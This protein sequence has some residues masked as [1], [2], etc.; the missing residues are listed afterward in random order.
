LISMRVPSGTGALSSLYWEK[1]GGRRKGGGKGKLRSLFL[2]G[3]I[4]GKE[5][6]KREGVL[7]RAPRRGGKEGFL[8]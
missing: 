6:G 5:R 8:W 1:K 4:V 7:F 3:C 2:N